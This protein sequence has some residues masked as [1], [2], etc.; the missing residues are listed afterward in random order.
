[1]SRRPTNLTIRGGLPDDQTPGWRQLPAAAPLHGGRAAAPE[2]QEDARA[3]AVR[4]DRNMWRAI[5]QFDVVGDDLDQVDL[6]SFS[7]RVEVETSDGW[8]EFCTVHWTNLGMEW[9]DVTAAWDEVLRQHREGIHPGS[10][11]DPGRREE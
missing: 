9:S 7:I 1:M 11:N 6:D 5:A 3:I 4:L 8:A 2:G 10:P